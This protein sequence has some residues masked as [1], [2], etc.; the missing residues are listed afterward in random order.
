MKKRLLPFVLAGA[1]TAAFAAP[2]SAATCSVDQA[3][4]GRGGTAAVA[5]LIAAAVE[6]A[7]A[8]GVNACDINIAN[9]S[10][11]NLLRNADILN[12]SLNN[13]LRNADIIDDV[14]V[15]VLSGTIDVTLVDDSVITITPA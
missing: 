5:A 9:D 15:N 7:V 10:L 11:N 2:A 14:T 12:N 4:V 6:A 3:D 1:L 8:A 13:L